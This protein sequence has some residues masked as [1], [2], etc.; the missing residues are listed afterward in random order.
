MTGI[1]PRWPHA[2]VLLAITLLAVP[3]QADDWPQW[4]GP[5]R[6]NVWKETG[7][8]EHFPAGGLKVRW[9]VPVGRGWSSPVVVQGR[10]YVTDHQHGPRPV[11]RVL[12]VDEANGQ[13]LWTHTFECQ[14][15]ES[16]WGID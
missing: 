13:L 9:R 16:N 8:L 12:C 14:Y 11:D 2:S 3:V 10:V 1:A 15:P 6:D 4:R 5:N 7:I